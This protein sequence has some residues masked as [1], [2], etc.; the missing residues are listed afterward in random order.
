MGPSWLKF[1]EGTEARRFSTYDAKNGCRDVIKFLVFG[2]LR[3]FWQT[4]FVL[5]GERVEIT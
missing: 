3:P 4:N 5:A 1:N 2:H